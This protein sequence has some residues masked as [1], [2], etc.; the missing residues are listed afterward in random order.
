MKTSIAAAFFTLSLSAQ[1]WL[2]DSFTPPAEHAW[3]AYKMTPLGPGLERLDYEAYMSSIE[4][5]RS[6]FGSGRWP[7]EKITMEDA[8]KDV[9]G[10]QE[11]FRARKAFTYAV[12]TKDGTR[13][14]GCVY[15]RPSAK[16]GYDAQVVMWVTKEQ[17][18]KGFDAALFAEVK[19]WLAAQWPFQ[20]VAYPG[21]SITQAEW[22]A[23]PPK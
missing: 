7:H 4:H 18:D 6:T 16:R 1:S 2:P 20:S 21:R 10:E 14:L 11:R 19:R 12:L 8:L 22:Q 17:F 15:I 5:L 13:E 23:L 3:G 9:Q